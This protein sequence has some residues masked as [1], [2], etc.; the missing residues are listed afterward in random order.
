M[1][2]LKVSDRASLREVKLLTG[3]THQVR[4]HALSENHPLA[5]DQRYGEED[6]NREMK[7]LGLTRLFLHASQ[8]QLV[9][10]ISGEKITAKAELPENLKDLL[11]KLELS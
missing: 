2:P 1:Q 5:G 3:R 8:L 9:H 7:K 11:G 10:P 6:F 4:V